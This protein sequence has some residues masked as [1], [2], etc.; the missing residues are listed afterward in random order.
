MKS[1]G[2][3]LSWNDSTGVLATENL[4]YT[5]IRLSTYLNNVLK[6]KL[7]VLILKILIYVILQ[8]WNQWY[9]LWLN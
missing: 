5:Y 6:N 4:G 2:E 8:S 1:S 7:F 3:L 9:E